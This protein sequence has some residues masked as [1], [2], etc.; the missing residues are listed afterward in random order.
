MA[1]LRVSQQKVGSLLAIRVTI[2]FSR[3]TLFHVDSYFINNK[4]L[5]HI[6]R[7]NSVGLKLTI[8]KLWRQQRSKVNEIKNTSR[9]R[10]PHNAKLT[11]NC[12][13]MAL[14]TEDASSHFVA[15][16]TVSLFC[17][18]NAAN[19]EPLAA[20]CTNPMNQVHNHR[21]YLLPFH[22]NIILP[23]MLTS[24]N[25]FFPLGFIIRISYVHFT[26]LFLLHGPSI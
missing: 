22:F 3:R 23:S 5:A 13:D 6:F 4:Q 14:T 8:L 9:A 11:S 20:R 25:L 10:S 15:Q 18:V 17:S 1:N 16:D 24:S 21:Y 2:R 12:C 26:T 19:R 7:G